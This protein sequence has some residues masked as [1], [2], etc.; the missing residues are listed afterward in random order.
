MGKLVF[1]CG[2]EFPILY[3]PDDFVITEDEYRK[4]PI[5]GV[6]VDIYNLPHNCPRTWNLFSEGHTKGVFQLEA[7]LGRMWSRRLKPDSIE[8]LAALVAVLRP[9]SLRAFAGNPPKS[10]TQ[11]YVDRKHKLEDV[12][13]IHPALEDVLESTY[14][15]LLYQEEAMQLASKLAGFTLQ[16]ADVLR[17]CLAKGSLVYTDEGPILIEDLCHRNVRILTVDA[18]QTD[19]LDSPLVYKKLKKV[20]YTGQQHTYTLVC[21]T[22]HRVSVTSRHKIK[23]EKG[24]KELRDIRAGDHVICAYALTKAFTKQYRWAKVVDIIDNGVCDTYDYEVDDPDI[25]Y[26]FVNG[27]L[28]HNSIGKKKA[29]MMAKVKVE[30]IEGCKKQAVVSEEQAEEIF[31]WIVESQKYQFNKSHSVAYSEGA[32]W[33]AYMKAHFPIQ[34]YCSFLYGARWKPDPSEEVYELVNDAKLHDIDVAVPQFTDQKVIPYIKNNVIYFGLGDIKQVGDASLKKLQEICRDKPLSKWSWLDYLVECGNGISSLVTQALISCGALDCFGQ[35]RTS[36]LYELE[37][38]KELTKK[39]CEWVSQRSFPSL[40]HALEQCGVSKKDGGGCHGA[41]RVE[42]VKQLTQLLSNPPHELDDTADFI[43]WSEEKF[44]GIPLTCNKVDGCKDA[45]RA[46]CTCKDVVKGYT[47]YTVLAA[48]IK[49]VN[50][51]KTK[52]GKTPG[53][54]MAFL[55]IADHSCALDDVVAFPDTWKEYQHLLYED[56]TV[57]IQGEQKKQSFIINKVWQI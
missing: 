14:G 10:M 12:E 19:T 7:Q 22:G 51:I 38:W 30:F 37:I 41:K 5:K 29:D 49:R 13:Y 28:V 15:C 16:Q 54:K 25:H 55:G 53:R 18:T 45:V 17:K 39:E 9:G 46:N 24:W 34:F 42:K 40:L 57:L 11:R 4:S 35:S 33:T 27:I 21:S 1:D 43:A 48:E 20:W 44:L 32:Y 36:M 23:T 31:G 26:G 56:N 47:G 52:K 2:C 3:T 50:E 8:E 6:K